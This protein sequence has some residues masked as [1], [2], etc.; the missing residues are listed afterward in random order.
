MNQ[1]LARELNAIADALPLVFKWVDIQ[2]VFT[3]AEL[4]LTPLGEILHYEPSEQYV[5]M[6][7]ALEAT[8]HGKQVK[9][10]YR[11]GGWPAV[12]EYKMNI[13]QM[14]QGENCKRLN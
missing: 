4:N 1:Q 11:K 9:D 13:L 10:A 5:V 12:H 8:E 14:I 2:E 3:G 6:M 7:P